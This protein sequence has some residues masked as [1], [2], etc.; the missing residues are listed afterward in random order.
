[1]GIV[2]LNARPFFNLSGVCFLPLILQCNI[3]E[4]GKDDLHGTGICKDNQLLCSFLFVQKSIDSFLD[5]QILFI[6]SFVSIT[7]YENDFISVILKCILKSCR[8]IRCA[9]ALM[10]KNSYASF[11]TLRC[12]SRLKYAMSSNPSQMTHTLCL[13]L[14][15]GRLATLFHLQKRLEEVRLRQCTKNTFSI[16]F[17]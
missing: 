2:V 8:D 12:I 3:T 15:F 4:M 11:H 13:L 14:R 10:R 7:E 17:N 16:L 5:L 6:W 1:M 9:F